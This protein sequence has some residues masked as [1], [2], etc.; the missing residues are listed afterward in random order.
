VQIIS[1]S[2]KKTSKPTNQPNKAILSFPQLCND[3]IKT[4]KKVVHECF[5]EANCKICTIKRV[6]NEYKQII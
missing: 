6:S 3:T 1:P 2:Q 4:N 5:T